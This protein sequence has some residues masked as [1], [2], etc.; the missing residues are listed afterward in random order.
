MQLPLFE[1]VAFEVLP[2]QFAVLYFVVGQL[3]LVELVV[4]LLA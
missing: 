4:E 1:V 3:V 2:Q